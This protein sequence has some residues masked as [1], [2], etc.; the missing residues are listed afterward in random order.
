MDLLITHFL[1]S[2]LNFEH[3]SQGKLDHKTIAKIAGMELLVLNGNNQN[4][5]NV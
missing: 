3:A 1:L 5:M 2:T 4:V